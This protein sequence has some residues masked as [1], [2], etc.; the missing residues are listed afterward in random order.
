MEVN[1]GQMDSELDIMHLISNM[2]S[3]SWLFSMSCIL[4]A[5][6]QVNL[7]QLVLPKSSPPVGREPLGISDRGFSV[8]GCTSC[9]PTSGIKALYETHYCTASVIIF[10]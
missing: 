1:Y 5:V 10:V 3:F 2:Y 9:C 8:S 6:F 4:L 7:C